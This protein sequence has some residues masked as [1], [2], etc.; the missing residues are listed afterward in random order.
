MHWTP[1]A[2]QIAAR[3]VMGVLE[4]RGLLPGRVDGAV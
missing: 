2:H 3:E 1:L 4:A